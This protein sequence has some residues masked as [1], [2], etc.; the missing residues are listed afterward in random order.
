V[1]EWGPAEVVSAV[2]QVA[3]EEAGVS[4]EDPAA[5]CGREVARQAAPAG[6]DLTP[7]VAAELAGVI[8]RAKLENR[9]AKLNI[10]EDEVVKDV[11]NI[12]RN[13]RDKLA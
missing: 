11:L 12:W 3:A 1:G 10:S 8:Y 5:E 9:A 2:V 7:V 13:V 6:N 4:V